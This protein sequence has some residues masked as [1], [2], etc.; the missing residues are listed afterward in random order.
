MTSQSLV[1]SIHVVQAVPL[2]S[3]LS[4]DFTGTVIADATGFES[5]TLAVRSVALA[6]SGVIEVHE[7]TTSG[8]T[9]TAV[10]GAALTLVASTSQYGHV[11]VGLAA[12]GPFFKV[13]CDMAGGGSTT[14]S[15][16][17]ILHGTR[18]QGGSG[19]ETISDFEV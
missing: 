16:D 12:R 9:Y 18:Y 10:T 11:N 2:A 14:T 15:A 6:G 4:A 13:F 19:A 5:L 8:G 7:S 1:N 3:D 17:L